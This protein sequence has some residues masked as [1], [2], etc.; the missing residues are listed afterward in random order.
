[1]GGDKIQATMVFERLD[2]GIRMKKQNGNLF[3]NAE[4]F[5]KLDIPVK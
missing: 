3:F 4:D 5:N 1:M 2:N